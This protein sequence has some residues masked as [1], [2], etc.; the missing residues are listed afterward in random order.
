MKRNY[1][2]NLYADPIEICWPWFEHCRYLP[3]GEIFWNAVFGLYMGLSLSVA[4]LFLFKRFRVWA[5]FSFL[6]LTVFKLVL[7]LQD[8][9]M[10]GNYHYMVWAVSFAYLFLPNKVVVIRWMIVLFYFFAGTLKLN[11]E[12]LTAATF[13]VPLPLDQKLVEILCA[14]TIVLELVLIWGL[15]AR[16][17]IYRGFVLVNLL[18]FHVVSIGVVGYFYPSVMLCLLMI[19]LLPGA[20]ADGASMHSGTFFDLPTSRLS[21][22]ALVV[23]L[24]FQFVP[25]FYAGDSAL[26]SQGRVFNLNMLDAKSLCQDFIYMKY[27]NTTVEVSRP[28]RSYGVRIQCDPVVVFAEARSFCENEK[29]NPDFI[30][31]DVALVSSRLT[32][33]EFTPIFSYRNF[34]SRKLRVGP[35]GG[36]PL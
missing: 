5:Y 35:L 17:K 6:L 8:Y 12:W 20:D 21:Q 11:R 26:T 4:V 22:S 9:R 16:Q 7:F 30:D 36:L 28:P 33:A 32:G 10:M 25:Y 31:L 1:L 27:K 13:L 24:V 19:F 2:A 15:L 3:S 18:V 14:Y 23:L 29:N 34:C